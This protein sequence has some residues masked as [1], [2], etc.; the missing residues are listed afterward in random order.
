MKTVVYVEIEHGKPVPPNLTDELAA[1][2]HQLVTN[3]Q[4]C[5]VTAKLMEVKPEPKQKWEE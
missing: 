2:A 5:E 1:R 4:K 3:T